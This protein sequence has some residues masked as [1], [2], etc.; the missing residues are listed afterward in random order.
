MRVSELGDIQDKVIQDHKLL[1]AFV[2]LHSELFL[3]HRVQR[4][5]EGNSFLVDEDLV[6]DLKDQEEGEEKSDGHIVEHSVNIAI[7]R[8][9]V[10]TKEDR[11]LGYHKHHV[12]KHLNKK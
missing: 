5:V 12:R 6:A 10:Y 1:L 2:Y 7:V 11:H 8:V 4:L 3:A 9:R